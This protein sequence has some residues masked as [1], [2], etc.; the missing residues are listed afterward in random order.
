MSI[1]DD[2]IKSNLPKDIVNSILFYSNPRMELELQHQIKFH[3]FKKYGLVSL[4]N[5]YVD[6]STFSVNFNMM[7]IWSGMG[8][9][10]VL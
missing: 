6:L 10:P 2:I 9:F 7:R 1:L 4:N 8:G 3:K 5:S